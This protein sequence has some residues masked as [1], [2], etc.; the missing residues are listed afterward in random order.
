MR[1]SIVPAMMKRTTVMGLYW[2]RRWMRSWACCTRQAG[3]ARHGGGGAGH[4]TDGFSGR[5]LGCAQGRRRKAVPARGARATWP[6]AATWRARR[7]PLTQQSRCAHCQLLDY[8]PDARF[9]AWP[10]M[11]HRAP[12]A[13]LGG[14]AWHLP[15]PH[16]GST[17]DPSS[18]RKTQ[19]AAVQMQHTS[20]SGLKEDRRRSYRARCVS[21]DQQ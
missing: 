21:H 3:S 13:P 1:S 4:Q 8:F 17:R 19:P 9:K 14:P 12:R 6:P 16:S 15:T 11:P 5:A 18:S 10:C 20:T 2:P 7:S